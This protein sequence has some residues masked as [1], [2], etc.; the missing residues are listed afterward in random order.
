MTAGAVSSP[1]PGASPRADT[2]GRPAGFWRDLT[3]VAIRAL[4]QIPRE[5][6][7][8]YPALV[9]PLFFFAVNVG[10]LSDVASFAGVSDFKAFQIPVAIVFAVTG[11][12]RA[13]ALVVDITGGYFDRLLVTPMHRTALLLGLMLADLALVIALSV[14]V[15]LL[16]Y[17]LGVRFATGVAGVLVFLLL[18]GLWGLA[19]TG[20]PYAIA[21]RT[22]S[23][24]AVNSSFLLFF[25]FA[26]LTTTF[27]PLDALSGWLATAARFNPVTY[28]LAALRA[29]IMD[30]WALTPLL[31]GLAAIAGVGLVSFV[32]AFRSLRSRTSR[33]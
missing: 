33:R 4:R 7:A 2:A 9:I 12:S 31:Q 5:P 16:G 3:S 11:V 15:V 19:F 24:A 13:S 22:G 6:E 26:F 10:T 18:A 1:L 32:L 29:L 30:G 8:I 21:L 25:P 27:L 20:F 23:P 17:V 28:L 14:P